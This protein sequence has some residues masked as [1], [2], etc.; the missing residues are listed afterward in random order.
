MSNLHK[1]NNLI[2]NLISNLHQINNKN[3]IVI[4]VKNNNR[5][6]IAVFPKINHNKT[7]KINSI[8]TQTNKT[9]LLYKIR[10]TVSPKAILRK[11]LKKQFFEISI[12]LLIYTL[13]LKYH[14][15]FYIFLNLQIQMYFGL[16]S[17]TNYAQ[18]QV[19]S[20][21]TQF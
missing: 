20:S 17:N 16:P 4:L 15:K 7:M 2:L 10:M 19:S 11:L 21:T 5:R 6:I 12:L 3:K 9:M 14:N 1:I 18:S 13:I 8:A